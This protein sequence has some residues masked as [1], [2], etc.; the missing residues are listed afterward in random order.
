MILALSDFD[1][2]YAYFD[3]NGIFELYYLLEGVN[4]H[5]ISKP[6]YRGKGRRW[7]LLRHETGKNRYF[8]AG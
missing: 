7:F 6:I 2:F 8:Q 3:D 1:I 5:K 4:N